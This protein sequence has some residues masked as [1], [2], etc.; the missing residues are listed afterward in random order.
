MSV[1][2][3]CSG[4][5]TMFKELPVIECDTPYKQAINYNNYVLCLA[6]CKATPEVLYDRFVNMNIVCHVIKPLMIFYIPE[7]G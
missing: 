3:T 6:A 7:R 2:T 4:I 5:T 1:K